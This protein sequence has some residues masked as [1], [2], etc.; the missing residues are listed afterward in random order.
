MGDHRSTSADSRVPHA[1][2][3]GDCQGTDPG[4]QRDRQGGRSSSCRRPGGG[5]IGNPDID[6]GHSGQLMAS[7]AETGG[8]TDRCAPEHAAAVAVGRAAGRAGTP[9]CAPARGAAPRGLGRSPAPTRPAAAPAPG[10]WWS[11]A[12]IL[13][14]GRRGE[15]AGLADSKLLT[16]AARE[17]V[18]A[19]VV[20]AG[21]GVRGRGHPGR[22]GRPRAGCTSATSPAM[23]RALAALAV[24]PA[25]VLTDGFPVAGLRRTRPARCGRATG[26]PPASPARQRAGQGHPGPDHGRAARASSRRT[27]SPSTRDTCTAEHTAALRE[28]GPCRGAPVLA[29]STWRRRA[30]CGRSRRRDRRRRRTERGR[31]AGGRSTGRRR[32]T[33]CR[34][35]EGWTR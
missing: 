23:R 25:Y 28:H 3:S 16:P 17:R 5:P 35:E 6:A 21:R 8:D 9:A 34:G 11:A 14:T 29:T 26:S 18:Y 2:D 24:D 30:G 31:R 20:A 4:G 27:A 32:T 15:V 12:A 10:R 19:E 7:G 22:G 13:P 1:G 33:W